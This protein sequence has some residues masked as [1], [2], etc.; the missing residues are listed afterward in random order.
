L[1]TLEHAPQD[2]A[3]LLHLLKEPA[4]KHQEHALPLPSMAKLRMM[5]LDAEPER[6]AMHEQYNNS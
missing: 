5:L 2:H 3:G 1:P 6:N 4:L